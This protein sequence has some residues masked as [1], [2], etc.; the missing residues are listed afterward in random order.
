MKRNKNL[1][2]P[3]GIPLFQDD[4]IQI[5]NESR[6][7]EPPCSDEKQDRPQQPGYSIPLF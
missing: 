6:N 7:P 3:S 5:I 2:L 1:I 4:D